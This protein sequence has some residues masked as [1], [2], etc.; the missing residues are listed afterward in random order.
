MQATNNP[1]PV[2][3]DPYNPTN[4]VPYGKPVYNSYGGPAAIPQPGAEPGPPVAY[5][6]QNQAEPKGF[7]D[8][9]KDKVKDV[10]K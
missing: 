5:Q 7:L 2:P 4:N 3:E 8:K 9:M 1:Y 10:L 6:S